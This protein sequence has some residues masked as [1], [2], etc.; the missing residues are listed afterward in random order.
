MRLVPGGPDEVRRLL[1]A[2]ADEQAS[3]LVP[4]PGTRFT[5]WLPRRLGSPG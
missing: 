3:L 5:G 1:R 4:A 2:H